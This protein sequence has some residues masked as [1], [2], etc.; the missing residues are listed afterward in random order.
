MVREDGHADLDAIGRVIDF[1]VLKAKIGGW[2][3]EH[4]DH[5]FILNAADLDGQEAMAAFNAMRQ[6]ADPGFC[7]K[8]F[9]MPRNP[10]A[11]NMAE[12]LLNAVG[13]TVLN[14]TGVRLTHVKVI[15]T[16]NCWAE[17]GEMECSA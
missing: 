14:G 15:E 13:P 5:G 17:A 1:S 7:Q 3:D 6:K 9:T 11:E 4:W 12:Y 2:I 10:T 16:E 8:V